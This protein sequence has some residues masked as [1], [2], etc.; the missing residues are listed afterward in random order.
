MKQ[1]PYYSQFNFYSNYLPSIYIFTLYG[2]TGKSAMSMT[3]SVSKY[4]SM[5]R[6]SAP[7]FLGINSKCL[8]PY[9]PQLDREENAFMPSNESIF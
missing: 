7:W 3:Y 9:I 8:K 2:L 5:T 1:T 6:I 4:E